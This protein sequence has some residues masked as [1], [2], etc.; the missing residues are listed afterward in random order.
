MHAARIFT[1]LLLLATGPLSAQTVTITAT[2]AQ[3]NEAGL[4]AGQVMVNRTGSTAQALSVLLNRSGSASNG[5]DYEF[6]ASSVSIPAG[7]SSQLL[8]FRPL[9]DN[10]VE[11]SESINLE[12][13]PSASYSVGAANSTSLSL[14]DDPP[15]V[16]II[17]NDAEALELGLNPAR[18]SIARS[19]GNRA[20]A[21]TLFLS[22]AGSASNGNDY[23]F[24]NGSTFIPADGNEVTV[25]VTPLAD[26]VVE[27][28][29][30]VQLGIASNP[31]TYLVDGPTSVDLSMLDD[32][33]RLSL[34]SVDLEAAELGLNP[35]QVSIARSGGDR[36]SAL[37]VFLSRA[38]S[39]SNGNDYTF[40]NGSTFIP[41]NGNTVSVT[42]TPLADNVV[43]GTEIVQLGVASNPG[44]YLIDGAATLD[45]T[46]LDD[47]PRLSLSSVDLEAAE[48][49]LNPG[50]VSIARSGGDRASALTIFLS[51][52]GSASNGNDYT[53]ING[54]TFIPANGN[55]VSVTVMPLADNFVEGTET[56]QLGIAS[57]PGVYLIDGSAI[58]DLTLRDDPAVV[59]LSISDALA[60]EGPG[61]T[62]SF[63]FNRSGGDLAAGLPIQLSVGGTA[64][65]GVDYN[66]IASS[67]T[68]PVNQASATLLL[69]PILDQLIEGPES[70][71]IT[72]VGNSSFLVG[73]N[74]SAEIIILDDFLFRNGFE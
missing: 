44:S 74:S 28:T 40:I 32:P 64:S 52:A 33:P 7:A 41:A 35:G 61:G 6:V 73:T 17:V 4:L 34:S 27:G 22:R 66:F 5:I 53:F 25:T 42:V 55:E 67:A 3:A 39:A 16:S 60:S 68:M 8:E 62:G 36:A 50:Q 21:L 63:L 47:P 48:L 45:V 58:L 20:S 71:R 37:T 54:S 2:Q 51:R 13:L 29:E 49:A 9:A 19:G 56:V 18:I 43:E 57:N 14:L 72:L 46:L 12:I 1:L 15:R 11:G 69:Q 65:N 23:T 31:G 26:N 24:I 70:V 38:G 30:I 59:N 10:V